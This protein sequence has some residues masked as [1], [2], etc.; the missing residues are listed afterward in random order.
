VLCT[1]SVREAGWP[2]GSVTPYAVSAEEDPVVYL[3]DIAEHTHNLQADDRASLLVLDPDA[4]DD[5]QSGGRITVLARARPATEGEALET[6]LTRFPS[7][8]A[9]AEA[10]GFSAFVLRVEKVRWIAGFGHMGWTPRDSW[11]AGRDPL[12]PHALPIVH[13]MNEDHA[14]ALLQIVKA[15]AGLHGEEARMTTVDADGF[16]VRVLDADRVRHA[17]IPFPEP[18]LTPDHARKAMVALVRRSR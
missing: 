12:A 4:A 10:H 2:F 17:R 9:Y 15:E 3:S 8:R 1:T 11:Q 18:V 16:E 6:Y 13:H 5:P 7:A 14:D